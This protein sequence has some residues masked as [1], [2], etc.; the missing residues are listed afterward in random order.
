MSERGLDR[1]YVAEL[2]PRAQKEE[3]EEHARA[4]SLP[5]RGHERR[6]KDVK[7]KKKTSVVTVTPHCRQG[8]TRDDQQIRIKLRVIKAKLREINSQ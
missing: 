5:L 4:R 2:E 6:G 8:E 1:D 3:E 7:E